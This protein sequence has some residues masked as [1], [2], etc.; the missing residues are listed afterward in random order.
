MKKRERIEELEREVRMLKLEIRDVVKSHI[1]YFLSKAILD[2]AVSKS[3]S[4]SIKNHIE[5][6]HKPMTQEGK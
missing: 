2:E 5:A 1:E 3:V 4:V 6:W